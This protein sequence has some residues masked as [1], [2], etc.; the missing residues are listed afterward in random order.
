MINQFELN[1]YHFTVTLRGSKTGY[2][3]FDTRFKFTG[4][5]KDSEIERSEDSQTPL[6]DKREREQTGYSYFGARYYD[7]DLSVWLS[8]DPLADKYPSMSAYMYTAG[9]PVML[10]DPD[11]KDIETTEE[12]W[13]IIKRG[14]DATLG[15]SNPFTYNKETG[16]VEFNKNTDISKLD[17]KQMEVLDHYKSLATDENFTVK[18][19][20]ISNE[21]MFLYNH[22]NETSL[23]KQ[24]SSGAEVLR[25]DNFAQVYLSDN[26]QKRT[27]KGLEPEIQKEDIQGITG[28][29][30]IGGHAYY[31]QQKIRNAEN[32]LKTEQFE[33]TARDCYRGLYLPNYIKKQ[34]VIPHTFRR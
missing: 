20:V 34:E 16:K 30:E 8:V 4:K 6:K 28:L 21:T 9:N 33:R 1:I 26:P 7:S 19:D 17:S 22:G 23:G 27:S 32:S 18:V 3:A 24:E 2:T 10:V 5:E 29:H 15:K 11:G 13:N 31:D 14:L 25:N 12:G